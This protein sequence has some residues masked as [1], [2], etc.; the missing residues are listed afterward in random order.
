M[1]IIVLDIILL[2][3][4]YPEELSSFQNVAIIYKK[5]SLPESTTKR[6]P[7]IV[8]EVSAML[9]EMMHF[10]TPAGAMSNT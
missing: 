1:D 6:T 3:E 5:C 8:T 7:S 4:Q 10:R 9:V 2:S